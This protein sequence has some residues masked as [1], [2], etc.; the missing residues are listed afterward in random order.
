MRCSLAAALTWFDAAAKR[1]RSRSCRWRSQGARPDLSRPLV[2]LGAWRRLSTDWFLVADRRA[3]AGKTTGD[4]AT[5]INEIVK[6]S[7]A[8]ASSEQPI[9]LMRPAA[10]KTR[11]RAIALE[12]RVKKASGLSQSE[13]RASRRFAG[14]CIAIVLHI[15][16]L[17][18]GQFDAATY[19]TEA[20]RQRRFSV[21]S[22][23]A[24]A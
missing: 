8:V 2:P 22:T 1:R 5:L 16:K 13:G 21:S 17:K 14:Y 9:T 3:R 19:A 18:V 23:T 4:F 7:L 12:T 11:G 15:F 20:R 24:Y 10:G 6:S